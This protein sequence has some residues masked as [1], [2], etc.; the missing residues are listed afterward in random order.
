MTQE[1]SPMDSKSSP[2][3]RSPTRNVLDDLNFLAGLK[4]SGEK[5]IIVDG[6]TL[7][8]ATVVAVARSGYHAIKTQEELQ[9]LMPM[10]TGSES[11]FVSVRRPVKRLRKAHPTFKMV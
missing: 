11:P 5:E 9:T 10:V 8:V 3:N 6:R 7:D 4:R 1:F 2:A